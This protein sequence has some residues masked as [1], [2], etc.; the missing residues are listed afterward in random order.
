MVMRSGEYVRY[1]FVTDKCEKDLA[2]MLT[3]MIKNHLLPSTV[4]TVPDER[5]AVRVTVDSE[6]AT[7]AHMRV[8]AAQIDHRPSIRYF[9]YERISAPMQRAA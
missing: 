3:C 6:G 1:I 7:D 5:G 8:I 2:D 4:E 9:R